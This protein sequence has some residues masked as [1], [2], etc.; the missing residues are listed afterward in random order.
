MSASDKTGLTKQGV[1]DLNAIGPKRTRTPSREVPKQR[2]MPQDPN[3]P[4]FYLS[5]M[6]TCSLPHCPACGGSGGALS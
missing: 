2:P 1:R 3:D 6:R 5:H 4:W